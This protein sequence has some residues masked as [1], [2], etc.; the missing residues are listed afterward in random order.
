[1]EGS[2]VARDPPGDLERLIA[3]HGLRFPDDVERAFRAD[4]AERWRSTNRVAFMVGIATF[5]A[6]GLVDVLATTRSLGEVWLLRF[7][8]GIPPAVV[9]LLLSYTSVFPR[10]MQPMTA[11]AVFVF[12]ALVVAME[13]VIG[14]DEIGHHLYLF[15]VAPVTAFAYAAPRLRF[16]YATATGW[17]I[18]LAMLTVGF[19]HGV[20]STTETAIDFSVI[21]A[22][23]AAVNVAGMIG[24]YLM[25]AGSRRG[26]V[27]ELVTI[28][29]RERSELLLHN[30]LPGSVAERLKR[31]WDVAEGFEEATV[32]F[33]D[34]VDFTPFAQTQRPHDLMYLLNV[35][36]TRF[37]MVA[38]RYGL[39]KI[40]TIGDCYMAVGGVPIPQPDHAERVAES[41]LALLEEAR[42]LG[43]EHGWPCELRIGIDTGPVVA[44]VIGMHKFSYDLWGDTVNTASRMQSHAAP[45]EIRVTTSTFQRLV[46]RYRFEGPWTVSVK[47]KGA[48]QTYVLT[49]RANP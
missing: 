49:G 40:K 25:E 24:A 10:L 18:W 35:L 42:S 46:G 19:D 7:V 1:M 12:G 4:Y 9:V 44:G 23:L 45:G 2:G 31:G 6:F 16:W 8:L 47:G 15:G 29:E 21:M 20:W 5:A 32:M 26:F 36:F 17:A 41:G 30:I 34:L 22:L 43:R 3:G 14:P 11:V 48:L 39:E 27:Q 33:A 38:A 37:D 13:I 28:R